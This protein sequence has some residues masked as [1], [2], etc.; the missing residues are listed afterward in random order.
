[1]T[2]P[3]LGAN[4]AVALP[5][6]PMTEG[7][8]WADGRPPEQ[9]RRQVQARTTRVCAAISP[10]RWRR[11]E[12]RT[13]T[14]ANREVDTEP[15]QLPAQARKS[16]LVGDQRADRDPGRAH[17]HRPAPRHPVH[18]GG[19][20]AGRRWG[21]GRQRS[22]VPGPAPPTP[23]TTARA[24]ET[25]RP[26]PPRNQRPG[27]A[28]P[29]VMPPTTRPRGHATPATFPIRASD[30][31]GVG[32]RIQSRRPNP[33]VPRLSIE[34]AL[35]LT[36][37]YIYERIGGLELDRL[38]PAR[39]EFRTASLPRAEVPLCPSVREQPLGAVSPPL[40]E[41]A[42]RHG[43]HR[44]DEPAEFCIELLRLLPEWR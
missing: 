43:G 40:A 33:A 29:I 1:M 25:P 41:R 18:L 12:T 34:L 17:R 44:V 4:F 2:G 7:G 15:R 19:R 36:A 14:K 3:A 27:R 35:T 42:V 37:Q 6:M 24:P 23:T 26:P 16:G 8:V 11:G 20:R 32:R 39:A 9:V 10:I 5:V 22:P 28:S 21:A 38:L 13:T 31:P 30:R